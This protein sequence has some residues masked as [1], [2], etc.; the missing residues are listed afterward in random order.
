MARLIRHEAIGPQEVKPQTDGK[1]QWVC[2]CGLSQNY[3]FCDGAH[4]TA[5]KE[6]AGKL[7]VYDANRAQVVEVRDE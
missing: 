3:P 5:R 2:M 7:Y 4:K 1:S 6:E